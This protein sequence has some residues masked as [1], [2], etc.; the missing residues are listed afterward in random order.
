MRILVTLVAFVVVGCGAVSTSPSLPDTSTSPDTSS[1]PDSSSTD[2]PETLVEA[3]KGF[4]TKVVKFKESY[5]APD[6]PPGDQFKLIRYRA[7]IGDLAAYVT[8]DPGDGAKHPAIVWITGGDNNSIGDVWSA[9]ERRNDQSVS[10]F[11]KAGVVMMFPSLRGGN[12]NPGKREGLYG[13]VDDVLAATDWQNCLTLIPTG[14]IWEAT[15]PV[16][17]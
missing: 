17:L 15:A 3:R 2:S 12:D 5:G 9:R 10:A 11:R 14:F 1:S 6:T 7:P 13:E 4:V 8:P 16:E